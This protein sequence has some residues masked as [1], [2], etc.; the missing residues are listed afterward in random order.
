M[1]MFV[2]ICIGIDG[3]QSAG[4]CDE[5]QSAAER[6]YPTSEIRGRNREDPMPEARRPRGVTPCQRSGAVAESARLRRYRNGREELPH[7]RG[8]GQRRGGATPRPRSGVAAERSYP[9]SEVRGSGPECQ[10]A[11]AQ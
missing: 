2:Y 3:A 5:A 11:T 4:S 10:A 1:Y 8:Q 7:I 9:V 6:K